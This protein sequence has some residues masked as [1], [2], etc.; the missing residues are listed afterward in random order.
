[1][2]GWSACA[3]MCLCCQ[4][5]SEVQAMSYL[6]K[7]DELL[8]W[9][10]ELRGLQLPQLPARLLHPWQPA[11][12]ALQPAKS[13]SA[14][15]SQ[16]HREGAGTIDEQCSTA[17]STLRDKSSKP[18]D[19]DPA[20]AARTVPASSTPQDQ[21]EAA[22]ASGSDTASIPFSDGKQNVTQQTEPSTADNH[23]HHIWS[24]WLRWQ[25]R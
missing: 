10:S 12:G 1:M 17:T 24:S 13:G 18:S 11:D 8:R 4:R 23:A 2:A 3:R 14:E 7:A 19:R 22:S 20:V 15:P 25:D 16:S 21:S 6:G 9:S 5:W